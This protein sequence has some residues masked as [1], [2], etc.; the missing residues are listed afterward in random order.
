MLVHRTETAEHLA[1]PLRSDRDHQREADRRVVGVAATNPVPELEHVDRVDPEL[2]HFG[3]IRRE[4]H[5]VLRHRR[6]IPKRR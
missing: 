2:P 6:L 5:E 4:R 1:E 3:G